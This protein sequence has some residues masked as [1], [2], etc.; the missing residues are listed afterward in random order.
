M[1]HVWFLNFY[2]VKRIPNHNEN[3]RI[4]NPKSQIRNPKSGIPNPNENP[5]SQ[6]PMRIRNP[7]SQIRN[8]KSQQGFVKESQESQIPTGGFEHILNPAENAWGCFLRNAPE[9]VGMKVLWVWNF[10]K[11]EKSFMRRP[12][13][14]CTPNE[15]MLLGYAP[16]PCGVGYSQ[17]GT[18]KRWFYKGKI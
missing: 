6:I 8:P 18:P 4:P 14:V 15:G 11:V 17:V 2:N 5:K 3:P 1:Y 7:K 13:R 10:L 16:V 9:F 12:C